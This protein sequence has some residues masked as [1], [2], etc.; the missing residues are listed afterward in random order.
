MAWEEPAMDERLDAG[1]HH[2]L[3]GEKAL[4]EGYLDASRSHFEAA[5]LQF[6]GP[7]L[8]LGEAHA[9]RGLARVELGT[10]NLHVA[11][12]S[13]RASVQQYGEV[14]AILRRLDTAGVSSGLA[15]DAEEGEAATLVL[16][17]DILVRIGRPDEA[18]AA[19]SSA[20][21]I[22]AAL[23]DVGSAPGVWQALGRLALRDGRLG[24]AQEAFER[25]VGVCE[26][27][28]DR[29]GE[30]HAWMATAEIL[31]LQNSFSRAEEVL[32]KAVELARGSR[33]R[34]LLG[35][36]LSQQ[37]ALF[38][39]LRRLDE[40]RRAYQEAIPRIVESGDVEGEGFARVGLGDVG[41]QLGLPDA[42]T[43][44]LRGGRLLGSLD[45]PH[46]L[47][48]ALLR[49]AA[50]ALR[51]GAPGLALAASESARQLWYRLDP[52]RGVGQ[53]LRV[54][55]KAL[56]AAKRWPA[57]ITVAHLRA[58]VAG[59]DQPNARHVRDF[60]RARAPEGL[61]D[62]L[63]RL[64]PAELEDRAEAL[65]AQALGPLLAPLDLD[66]SSLGAVGSALALLDAVEAM[67]AAARSPATSEAHHPPAASSPSEET[68]PD[69]EGLDAPPDDDD[70]QDDDTEAV[71]PADDRDRLQRLPLLDE[72]ADPRMLTFDDEDRGC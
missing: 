16:L 38:A 26:R 20:K 18:R 58:Q 53:A 23:G 17:G 15:R 33:Q 70:M 69:D 24:A 42:V 50:H 30:C 11:E 60:Y 35:R 34:V 8:R 62:A 45:H 31:R 12:Q 52:V 40:A 64:S 3:N 43:E 7:E 48:T 19:L 68:V 28:G 13:A 1:R 5:L 27:T 36:A 54:Q 46:G 61:R 71:E 25:A 49:V 4:D 59:N 44:L 14:R 21:T 47:G 63:D 10:G 51:I 66:A 55:V 6:R 56:A 39:Q 29:E 65:V 37:G 9:L 67:G 57:A 22:V 2:L 32:G 72:D 41:S